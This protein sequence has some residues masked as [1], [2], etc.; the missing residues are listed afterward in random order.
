MYHRPWYAGA[1][2]DAPTPTFREQ[3]LAARR[4]T[5]DGWLIGA[6]E[7]AAVL[8]WSRFDD[9]YALWHRKRGLMP[10]E[11]EL[12]ERRDAG[13]FLE[14]GILRWYAR[15]T[16]RKVMRPDLVAACM[17][18]D[19]FVRTR[20]DGP[21]LD[22]AEDLVQD[23]PRDLEEQATEL[24]RTLALYFEV[25]YGP[26][27]DGRVTL[28]SRKH[29]W[30]AVSPDAFALHPELGWGF[31]DAK[32]IDFDRSWDRG[33]VV[34][35]EYSAQIAHATMP[36]PWRWGGFA[37]CVAGQRLLVVDVVREAMAE[38]EELLAV[39]GPAFVDEL[40]RPVPPPP[41]GSEASLACLRRVWPKHEPRKAVGWVAPV[42]ACGEQWDPRAWD[43]S[44]QDAL[45]QRRA[46]M[47]KVHEHEIVLRHV[48]KDAGTVVLP[49]GVQYSITRE[50]ERERIR[51]RAR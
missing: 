40:D 6:S 44:Y 47:D 21:E 30:L 2:L 11:G 1:M 38:V 25:H 4:R 9:R 42:E 39:E 12:D 41:C 32:N 22:V 43:E 37:V 36:T 26:D 18:L 24:G 15:R 3:W 49:G 7:A 35:P 34:P 14:E 13:L 16:G 5:G 20:I 31:V 33:A 45:E 48:A 29:P 46:W 51:R 17:R 50:G 27:R 10:E 8:G 28:R 23:A 19:A